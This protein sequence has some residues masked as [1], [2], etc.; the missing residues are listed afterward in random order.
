MIN[1]YGPDRDDC[2]GATAF[3]LDD[4]ADETRIPIG[5]PICQHAGLCIWTMAWSL[6]RR[7]LRASYTSRA[8]GWRAVILGGRG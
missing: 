5:R 7:G 6:C 3:E 2:I 8:R 4:I 1:T